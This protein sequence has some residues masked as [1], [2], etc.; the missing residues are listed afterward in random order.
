[1]EN[2]QKRTDSGTVKPTIVKRTFVGIGLGLIIV[3]IVLIAVVGLL[4][5]WQVNPF[6]RYW[7]ESTA[8]P[9]GL[10]ICD[11]MDSASNALFGWIW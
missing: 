4:F 1:M 8:G 5:M 2:S 10:L 9:I 7:F 6:L 11:A 3:L